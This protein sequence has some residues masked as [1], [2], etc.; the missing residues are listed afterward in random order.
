MNLTPSN[1]TL[2][3]TPILNSKLYKYA[4]DVASGQIVACK[5]NIAGCKRFI[6]DLENQR[7]GDYRWKFDLEKAYRPIDFKERFM[8]PTKSDIDRM[9]LLPWQHEELAPTLTKPEDP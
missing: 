2:I 9:Q 5:K 7:Y 8:V 3:S 6:S 4:E 1:I